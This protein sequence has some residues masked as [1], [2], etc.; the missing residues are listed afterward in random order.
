V[1]NFCINIIKKEN[2]F[3]L[4]NN[5]HWLLTIEKIKGRASKMNAI[6]I[7]FLFEKDYFLK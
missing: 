4:I 2:H 1:F 6:C 5:F 3:T 7:Q